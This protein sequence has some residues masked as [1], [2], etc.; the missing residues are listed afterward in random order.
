MLEARSGLPFLVE[1]KKK[2]ESH[3]TECAM[4]CLKTCENANENPFMY[5]MDFPKIAFIVVT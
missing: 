2:G 3:I 5:E 4:L 1:K